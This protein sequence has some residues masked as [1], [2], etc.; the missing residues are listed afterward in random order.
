MPLWTTTRVP[1]PSRWGWAFSSV[2]RPWVAQRVWPMPKL[3]ETEGATHG[4]QLAETEGAGRG[5]KLADTEGAGD[6]AGGEGGLEVAELAGSATEF[7]ALGTAG[8]SDAGG[9]VAAV[10]QA[11]QALDDDG[12][13]GIRT[14]VADDSAHGNS[15]DAVREIL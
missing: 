6:G 1:E 9:I 15:L 12:H 8:D 3:A 7:E 11:A 4:P 10:L 5:P 2:G 14:D 13:G